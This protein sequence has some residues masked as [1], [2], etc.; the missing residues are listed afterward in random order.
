MRLAPLILKTSSEPDQQLSAKIEKKI[1][2]IE[3]D[4]EKT[5][6]KEDFHEKRS[7]E[8]EALKGGLLPEK[9]L[10]RLQEQQE[11][12]FEDTEIPEAIPIDPSLR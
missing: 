11:G 4:E 12:F 7:R 5:L 3:E 9:K 10:S 2:E 8:R 6:S 1:K